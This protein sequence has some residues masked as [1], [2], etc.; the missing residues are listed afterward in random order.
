MAEVSQES[1]LQ[2][3]ETIVRIGAGRRG[4]CKNYFCEAE[5]NRIPDSFVFVIVLRDLILFAE[6]RGELIVDT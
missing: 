5:L 4:L 3:S 6:F 1:L 2:A